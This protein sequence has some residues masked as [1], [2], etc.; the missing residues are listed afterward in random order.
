LAHQT[1]Q[2]EFREAFLC[3][4]SHFGVANR[5]SRERRKGELAFRRMNATKHRSQ[6]WQ[7]RTRPFGLNLDPFG[8]FLRN[9][10]FVSR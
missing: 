4:L 2:R 1:R 7:K 5:D 3:Q 6:Q 10:T 9:A 8:N